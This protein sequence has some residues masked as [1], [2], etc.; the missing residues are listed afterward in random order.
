MR[1]VIGRVADVQ[2]TDDGD[3]DQNYSNGDNEKQ[4]DT[5]YILK[6]KLIEIADGLDKKLR[7]IMG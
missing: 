1:E 3:L 7:E 6:I 5:W 2:D 4:L